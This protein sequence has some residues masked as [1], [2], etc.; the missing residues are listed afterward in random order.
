MQTAQVWH[1]KVVPSEDDSE[2]GK[3]RPECSI[4]YNTYD[5]VFKTPKMLECTHT[6]C[7]ECLS[8]VVVL[9]MEDEDGHIP[10]P[11]CRHPTSI[12]QNGAPALATSREVL[13]QLPAHQRHE[14]RVWLEGK[15]L[16]YAS[17]P[18]AH[19]STTCICIDIGGSKQD[20]P[21]TLSAP[22]RTGILGRLA[23]WKRLLLMAVLALLLTGI[24]LWPLY[25]ITDGNTACWEKP[26]LSELRTTTVLP[27]TTKLAQ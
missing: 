21:V 1:T 16:C 3:D 18:N 11:L 10:C 2:K 26:S 22:L 9:S 8:R 27:T 5:N 23:D 7:L 12:P 6:F 17:P 13:S 24:V 20:G 19:V 4:C 14:E 15:R 25:C